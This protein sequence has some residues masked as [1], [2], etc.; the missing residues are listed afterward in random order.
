MPGNLPVGQGTVLCPV[1]LSVS[2]MQ[3]A[4]S[5]HRPSHTRALSIYISIQDNARWL[6]RLNCLYFSGNYT[7]HLAQSLAPPH[8]YTHI[9]AQSDKRPSFQ[10][11]SFITIPTLQK[12]YV[13]WAKVDLYTGCHRRNGPNFGRVFLMLNYTDITQ[14]THVPSWTVIEI[15]AK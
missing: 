3:L 8:F 1:M 5:W 13:S 11:I 4:V 12:T 9:C 10:A 14:N 7:Y 2:I 6:P 15:M